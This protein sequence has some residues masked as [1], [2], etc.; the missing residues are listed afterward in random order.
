MRNPKI[1]LSGNAGS[2]KSTIGNLLSE[3]LMVDF[4]SIG[5]ICRKRAVEL[6]MDIN[7]FQEHLKDDSAFDKSMDQYI[8]EYARSKAGYVLDYRLGFYFLPDSF[9]VLL[10]VSDETALKRM[11]VRNSLDEDFSNV[12]DSEKLGIIRK[13][14]QKMRNRFIETYGVDFSNENSYDL[15]I[16]TDFASP[17]EITELI[18]ITFLKQDRCQ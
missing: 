17:D 11:S 1:V 4:I 15:I 9:K 2:G 5:A 16:D 8:S 12:P 3:R 14:N 6:R 13:R 7:E 10:K 18:L